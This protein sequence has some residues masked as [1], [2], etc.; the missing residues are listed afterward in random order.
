MTF[1]LKLD[2]IKNYLSKHDWNFISSQ[3]KFIKINKQF[4]EQINLLIPNTE[5]LIDYSSR[6]KD[7]IEALAVLENRNPQ[8]I[9][10]EIKNKGYD[11]MK[12]RF[13]ANNTKGGTIPLNDFIGVMNNVKKM[14]TF[15]ACSEI[16]EKSQYRKPFNDAKE[17]V[18][19]CEF[20]QTE[21]GSFVISIKVPLGRTYLIE[22]DDDNGYLND[23]GRK[24]VARLIQGIKEV[25]ELEVEDEN[26]FRN[27]YN[28]KLNKN[29]CE[30]IANLL[31]DENGFNVNFLVKWDSTELSDQEL[32]IEAEIKS[33]Q[34]FK[35]FN[36]MANYLKKIP[37]EETITIM[38][39]IKKLQRQKVD[40][41]TERKLITIDVPAL[42]RKVYLYL[43]DEDHRNACN[44]YREG[45]KIKVRGLLNK[46]TQ[47]WF[48]DNPT[49]FEI[50]NR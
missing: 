6:I 46:K 8:D 9:Q 31:K 32:P 10:E 30:A 42:K 17:L 44:A 21:A 35:K 3:D 27:D 25:E 40:Q 14:I 13:V 28:K 50:M 19:N 2:N 12:I 11:L 15:G 41:N 18:E 34:Y 38:G 45:Y 49:N 24:T 36:K 26:V 37:E 20:A 23:L 33:S 29:V 4:E 43:N 1:K 22:I 47:H 16:Q 5:D 48:L 7:L 39:I